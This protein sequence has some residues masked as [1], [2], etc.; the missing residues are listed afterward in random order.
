MVEVLSEKCKE[1]RATTD[2]F[3]SLYDIFYCLHSNEKIAFILR[4]AARDKDA[5]GSQDP[6]NAAGKEQS[7]Q[8]GT[9]LK[10][11]NIDDFFYMH[12][13]VYRTIQTA[14]IISDNKGQ[15]TGDESDWTKITENDFHAQNS[16]LYDSWFVKNS[17]KKD[18]CIKNYQSWGWSAYS[19]VAYREYENND[20]KKA[21]EEAF[22]DIDD[23]VQEFIQTNFTYDKMKPLTMAISHDQ[24]LVPFVVSI[25]NR[26]IHGNN[27]SDL[28]FHKYEKEESIYDHW[29]N[30]LTGVA[31]I[32]DP[33]NKTTIIP[34]T[35]LDDGFLR[36]Y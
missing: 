1:L 18:A 28:R 32:V 34:V 12:T 29:I 7:A 33:D 17:S 16:N 3:S 36:T 2:K 24:F 27:N 8:F 31:I 10:E 21:C 6:L 11:L 14:K 15:V 26:K 35:A 4:H 25:S 19:K 22:Y 23:K 13:S 5:H 20:I 9:K 30:Y